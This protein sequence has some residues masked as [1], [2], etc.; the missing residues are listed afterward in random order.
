MLSADIDA[1]SGIPDSLRTP[2]EMAAANGRAEIL[3]LLIE[4]GADLFYNDSDGHSALLLAQM[5]GHQQ[6]SHILISAIE[7]VHYEAKMKNQVHFKMLAKLFQK[8][9]SRNFVLHV[10]MVIC[11]KC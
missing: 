3:R 2:L 1:V 10:L 4:N 5:N 11:L 9:Y 7:K 8:V 6:C